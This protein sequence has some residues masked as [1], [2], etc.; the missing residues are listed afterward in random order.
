MLNVGEYCM[1]LAV[2]NNIVNRLYSAYVSR[3]EFLKARN[4]T[5][6]TLKMFLIVHI[7]YY[8]RRPYR[9][10]LRRSSTNTCK[11]VKGT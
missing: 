8:N 3:L 4:I 11:H 5:Q 9:L 7:G 1:N 6:L 10:F 2:A